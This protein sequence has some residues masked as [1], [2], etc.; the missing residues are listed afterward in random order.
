MHNVIG[1]GVLVIDKP[2]G[3]TSFEVIRRLK[4]WMKSEKIGHTG[5][6]D[7]LATGV[8]PLC[9]NQATKLVPFLMEGIKEYEVMMKLGVETDTQDSTGRVIR[10]SHDPEITEDMLL[11]TIKAFEGRVKQVP[12]MFSALKYHGKP[13][14][15]LAR[16][17]IELEREEREVEIK[18]I[19]VTGINVPYCSFTVS[20]SKGTYIRTLCADIGT[21]LSCGAHLVALRRVKTGPFTVRDS[22]SLEE[23]EMRSRRGVIQE[24]IIPLAEALP[25]LFP[26]IFGPDLSEKVRRGMSIYPRDLK[27]V[28]LP[29]LKIGEKVKIL[30][31]EG[32]LLAVAELL[33][34][35]PIQEVT[36]GQGVLKL[37]RVFV[38]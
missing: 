4:K 25:D 28:L 16:Q 37:N 36:N 24:K 23:A 31:R 14:Y 34:D 29:L 6:L 11:S 33:M 1:D 21:S 7:P 32:K 26:I 35:T 38:N 22:I 10:E 5:T 3:P 18:S 27:T 19:Q 9:F 12:P 15:Q 20:C 2:S 30:S 17:G 13:L 8:L